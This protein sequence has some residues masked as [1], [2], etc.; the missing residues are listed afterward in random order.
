MFELVAGFSLIAVAA[1]LGVPT[2]TVARADSFDIQAG[3]ETE[4]QTVTGT[5]TGNVASGAA[6]IFGDDAAIG[7]E[8]TVDAP[9]VDSLLSSADADSIQV[10]SNET[11]RPGR[12]GPY[13]LSSQ[14]VRR[15]TLRRTDNGFDQSVPLRCW[16]I[17]K[18]SKVYSDSCAQR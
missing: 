9:D 2:A 8:G 7:L 5:D 11:G 16:I 14:M 10:T 18:V 1:A 4:T 6:L 12:S 17:M 15:D 3:P 13:F